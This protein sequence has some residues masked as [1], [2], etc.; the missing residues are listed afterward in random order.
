MGLSERIKYNYLCMQ[1]K[2]STIPVYVDSQI[3]NV[4]PHEM[5][6]ALAL[7]KAGYEVRFLAPRIISKTADAY[8]NG[9]LFEF[10]S[11]EGS[12]SRS[13]EHI[14]KKAA[15]QSPNLVIDSSRVK[16]MRDRSIQNFL[17]TWLKSNRTGIKRI[18][19]VNR[20]GDVIDI[21]GLI[22]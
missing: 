20:S 18:L 10:K 9:V 7:G 11:P 8:V 21:N 19:F 3:K 12:S 5:H 1:S 2:K 15:K 14:L 13:I 6:S 16:N 4:L 17:I 22:R